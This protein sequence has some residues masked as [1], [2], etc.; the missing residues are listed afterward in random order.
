MGGPHRCSQAFAGD[1][2]QRE[3]GRIAAIEDANKVAGEM[4]D[5]KDLRGDFE[6][7][8]LQPA[9]PAQPALHLLRFEHF[10]IQ[11]GNFGQVNYGHADRGTI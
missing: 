5:G 3:E 2:A 11:R 10:A 4:L 9:R 8:A 6:L 7:S 1:I